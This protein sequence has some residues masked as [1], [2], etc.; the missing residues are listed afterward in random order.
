MTHY[1]CKKIESITKIYRSTETV[2]I[3]IDEFLRFLELNSN[4][5]T[6]IIIKSGADD[7]DIG[8]E[9]LKG[10][11]PI[12]KDFLAAR[13]QKLESEMRQLSILTPQQPDDEIPF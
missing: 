4:A 5:K 2:L 1:E 10:F 7:K 9:E 8:D 13:R 12:L 6:E 3:R 11:L